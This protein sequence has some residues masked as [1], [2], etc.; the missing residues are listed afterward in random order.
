ME[1]ALRGLKCQVIQSTSDEAPGLLAYV[2]HHLGAHHSPDV[3][4]GQ[5]E[6]VKAVSAPLAT[7]QRAASKAATAAQQ[8]LE[9]RQPPLH[10]YVDEPPPQAVARGPQHTPRGD[11]AVH[12]AH[13]ASQELAR[14]SAQREQVAQSIR[15][16]AQAYHFVDVE[17]G[18]RRNGQLIASD[19]AQEIA[20]IRAIAQPE[21]LSQQG[22]ERIEKAERVIPKRQA[23]IDFVSGY[24]PQQVRQLDL[25]PPL[26][27]VMHARLVPSY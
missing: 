24:V 3:F 25:T 12:E 8:R 11:Q 20:T 10:D 1:P 6:L 26:S 27:F 5:Q 16:I 21:G 14:I 15:R 19:I 18:G 7:K 17:R 13:A 22:M 2:D 4:H 23:T 9:P